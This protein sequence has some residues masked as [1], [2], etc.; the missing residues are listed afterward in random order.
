MDADQGYQMRAT[1]AGLETKVDLLEAELCYINS[2]LLDVGF[3]DGIGGLKD[4]IEE[5]LRTD[6]E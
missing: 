5:V 4:A 6:D 1:I 2:L 3:P